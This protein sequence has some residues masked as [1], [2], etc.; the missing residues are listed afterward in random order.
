MRRIVLIVLVGLLLA[1]IAIFFLFTGSVHARSTDVGAAAC[2][3][4]VG[5]VIGEHGQGQA[6]APTDSFFVRRLV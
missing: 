1:L 3:C 4:P 5:A 6:A 2:P